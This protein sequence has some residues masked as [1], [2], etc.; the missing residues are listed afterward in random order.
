VVE[1][2]ERMLV[3][4]ETDEIDNGED[5]EAWFAE[6]A[7]DDDIV[8]MGSEPGVQDFAIPGAYVE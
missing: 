8:M 4:M 5:I 7:I 3:E 1:E 2:R 6:G